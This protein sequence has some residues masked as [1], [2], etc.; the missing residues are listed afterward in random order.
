MDLLRRPV[1]ARLG[2]A[3]C[4]NRLRRSVDRGEHVDLFHAPHADRDPAGDPRHLR[5]RRRPVGDERDDELR[6]RQ[7]EDAGAVGQRLG[8]RLLDLEVREALAQH[9]DELG[10]RIRRRDRG[11]S[12]T[13]SAVSAPV[14][15]PTS[16]TRMPG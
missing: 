6:E 3:R 11:A 4:A 1:A 14:P 9:G 10:R 16:S 12:A 8:R 13:S 15:A 5:D 7:V 2:R